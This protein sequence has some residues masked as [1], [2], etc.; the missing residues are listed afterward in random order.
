MVLW[1]TQ[2]MEGPA[3]CL[4][5]RLPVH[6]HK[7]AR[8]APADT[9]ALHHSRSTVLQELVFSDELEHGPRAGAVAISL[10]A[11]ILNLIK[12]LVYPRALFGTFLALVV[13]SWCLDRERACTTWLQMLLQWHLERA[14]TAC[15]QHLLPVPLLYG[16]RGYA[17]GESLHC[18]YGRRGYACGESLHCAAPFACAS[19]VRKTRIRMPSREKDEA[20]T[21]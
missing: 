13:L 12:C 3:T 6:T 19:A 16:R 9:C 17:C 10:S 20:L 5:I 11:L 14:C 4:H 21:M 15:V 8:C 18:A 7:C 1:R 2:A